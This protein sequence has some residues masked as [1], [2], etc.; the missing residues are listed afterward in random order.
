MKEM[1][2]LI[3]NDD[4]IYARGVVEAANRLV[5]LG[6]S[7]TVVAPDRERSGA[8]QSI[9]TSMLRVKGGRFP[10]FD[11]RVRAFKCTG[12]PSD[13][14]T[15]GL[16]KIFPEAEMVLSGVNNGPNLGCDVYYSGTVGAAREGYFGDR[17]SVALSLDV[18]EEQ[19]SMDDERYETALYVIEWV[20]DNIDILSGGETNK[21]ALLNINIPNVP[22]RDI[23]GF[24]MAAAGRRRY[25]D[26]VSEYHAPGG[27]GYWI[28]GLPVDEEEHEGSD[29]RAV[30]DGY[31]ALSFLRHDTTDHERNSRLDAATISDFCE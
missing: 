31:V 28:R 7:V 30:R 3:S 16:E 23:K 21:G 2:I 12:T 9:D 4:G 27:L 14:V 22:L 1:K 13:C 10:G 6:H 19:R 18:S 15:L 20:L 25:R 5:E 24:R 11:E 26:R 8:G 17:F 29:V